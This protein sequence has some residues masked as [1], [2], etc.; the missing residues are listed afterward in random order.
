M[1]NITEG[2]IT[3]F[4]TST[5]QQCILT[6][7]QYKECSFDSICKVK[8]SDENKILMDKSILEIHC[9]SK[10]QVLRFHWFRVYVKRDKS[11]TYSA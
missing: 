1:R 8:L 10:I 5:F 3:C 11:H 9:I 7:N 4:W 6:V 2:Q